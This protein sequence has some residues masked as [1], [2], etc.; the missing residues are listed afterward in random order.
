MPTL[1]LLV[2]VALLA[3]MAGACTKAPAALDPTPPPARRADAKTQLEYGNPPPA[4]A[5]RY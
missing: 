3:F 5:P 4:P 2:S 1:R